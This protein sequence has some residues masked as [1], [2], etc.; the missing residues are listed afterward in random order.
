MNPA[1]SVDQVVAVG[2][3]CIWEVGPGQVH[4]A[5]MESKARS[6]KCAGKTRHPHHRQTRIKLLSL[7]E[8]VATLQE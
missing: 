1:L 8:A 2:T 5:A 6:Q 4:N 7:A 3:V